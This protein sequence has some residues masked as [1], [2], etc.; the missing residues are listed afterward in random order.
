MRRA[1]GV[2]VLSG[3]ISMGPFVDTAR[4]VEVFFG[5]FCWQVPQFSDTV[6]LNITVEGGTLASI[7]GVRF[8]ASYSLPFSGTAF[9]VGNQATVAGIF[10]GD[11]NPAHFGGSAALAETVRISLSTGNGTGTLKGVDG[12]FP[13]ISTVWTFVSTCPAGPVVSGADAAA[14]N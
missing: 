6:K 12:Q 7:H 3:L 9:V 13:T 8:N 1:L 11:L 14:E 2:A 4:A 10:T 5:E